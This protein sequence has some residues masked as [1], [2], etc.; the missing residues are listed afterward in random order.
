MIRTPV[1]DNRILPGVTL[2]VV[3]ELAERHGLRTLEEDVPASALGDADEVWVSSS[4]K[5][6]VPIIAIDDQPVGDGRPGPVWERI[7]ALYQDYKA[8]LCPAPT[9]RGDA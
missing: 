6:V 7:W 5:E 8:E 3:L 1:R 9:G 2:Q 4:T